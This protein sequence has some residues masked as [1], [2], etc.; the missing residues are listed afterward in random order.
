MQGLILEHLQCPSL[1]H[2]RDAYAV[3]LAHDIVRKL[4]RGNPLWQKW[5][6]PRDALAKAAATSWI[7]VED[8]TDSLNLLVGPKLTTTDVGQ[9]LRAFHEEAYASYPNDETPG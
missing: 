6:G 8:L 3:K 4:D 2:I 1:R 5:E 7:S 9:R